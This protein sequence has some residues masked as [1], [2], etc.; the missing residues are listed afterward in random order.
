MVSARLEAYMNTGQ[1]DEARDDGECKGESG[2]VRRMRMA[3][4]RVGIRYAHQ[5]TR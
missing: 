4:A 5:A 1:A 3:N 2:E